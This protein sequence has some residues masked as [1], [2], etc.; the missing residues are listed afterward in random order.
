[1]RGVYV[2]YSVLI[3]SRPGYNDI[4]DVTNIRAL[5]HDVIVPSYSILTPTVNEYFV[6]IKCS[7]ITGHFEVYKTSYKKI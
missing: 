3:G 1:M 7:Y 4:E 6:E 2:S 5:E